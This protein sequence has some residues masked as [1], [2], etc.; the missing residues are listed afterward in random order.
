MS[1]RVL[2]ADDE[3]FM[4]NLLEK[5]LKTSGLPIQVAAVA[6][7]GREALKMALEVLPDIVITDIEMPFMN[8]LELIGALKDRD[9]KT[10]NVIISGYDQFDYARTAISLGVTDY[11]LKPFMPKELIATFEKII[12][13]LDSQNTLKQNLYLLRRQADKYQLMQRKIAMNSLL[14]GEEISGEDLEGLG[15]TEKRQAPVLVCIISI[16]GTVWNFESQEQTEEFLKLIRSDYFS[17][18]Y[19]CYGIG[20][21]SG[22][23]VCCFQSPGGSEAALLE[24]VAEGLQ[25]LSHSMQ[26][27]Y[28]IILYGS[29]GRVY[30]GI[31]RIR[32]SY[33]DARSAW[34]D[35]LEPRKRIWMYGE[36]QQEILVTDQ[37]LSGKISHAKSCIRGAVCAGNQQ[38]ARTQLDGLMQ[39]YALESGKGS[40]YVFISVGELV[41]EIADDMDKQGLDKADQREILQLNQRVNV[42]S[43]LEV[44]EIMGRYLDACCR[45]VS[46]N[47]SANRAEAAVRLVQGYVEDHLM[48][49]DLSMDSVGD[50]AHFSV[51]YLR[52]IFKEVTGESFNEYLIRKRMEKAGALLRDTYLKIQE[53]ADRCGYENQRYFASS[54]K[55]FYG[56][57]P[58]EYKSCIEKKRKEETAD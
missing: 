57:T 17:G 54:F 12:R 30:R 55:K 19:S 35:V 50:I 27:Y 58:T 43:L 36:K 6:G 4:R 42:V 41:Y 7:D 1:Y 49:R 32:D 39:L 40:E 24:A 26:Q 16:N 44:K 51:S 21:E 2:I 5:S 18:Q 8:G 28:N 48:D 56:C 37:K 47:L 38:E 20:L 13:E 10:K 46:E 9:I 34:K 11:L 25:R 14:A 33:E 29:V 52:Q 45:I 31:S 53:I 3:I 22:K 23:L 15:F